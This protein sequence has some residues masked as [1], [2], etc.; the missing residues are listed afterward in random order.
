MLAAMRLFGAALVLGVATWG[1]ARL[2]DAAL[3]WYYHLAW[4]SYIVGAD[5]LNQRF[6]G[7]SLIRH[8]PRRFAWLALGSVGWWTLF[9]AINLR[10]GNWYYVMDPPSLPVRWTAGVVAFATVLPG[11]VVTAELAAHLVGTR[12]VRVAPLRWSVGKERAVLAVG[13]ACFLLPLLWPDLFFPLTWGSFVFLI[14]P[15]NRRHARESFLRDLERGEAGPFLRVLGAG[16]ICGL[17]WE[18]WNHWAR[19]KWIYTVPGFERLKLF[20]MPLLGF[21]GFPPFAVESVVATRC[22]ETLW[23]RLPPARRP[24]AA[25]AAFVAVAVLVAVVFPA[26]DAVTVES[27][28]VPVARLSVLDP[29]K[30]ARLAAAG[31]D[32]PEKLLRA[33]ETPE[34]RGTW[35]ARTS[36]PVPALMDVRARVELVMHRGLGDQR[37]R[38]LEVLGIRTVEDL[39][40]WP[41]GALAA[42]LRPQAV[43]PRDHFLERRVAAWISD[44]RLVARGEPGE[45]GE[46]AGLREVEHDECPVQHPEASRYLARQRARREVHLPAEVADRGAE[47]EGLHEH[48][49][50]GGQRQR[51][52]RPARPPGQR[53]TGGGQ[54]EL[55]HGPRPEHPAVHLGGEVP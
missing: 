21:L 52:D 39:R 31:L 8:D 7:R 23:S 16:L 48:E 32:T 5:A 44:G 54:R 9:E 18:T 12:P 51:P 17:L 36:L 10:L 2:W 19:M 43:S 24:Q 38:Q 27:F 26:A 33:L 25:T 28:Y 13:G 37:A 22:V 20:E 50:Q 41:P 14:E 47:P 45:R 34:G 11:I 42:A 53:R 3:T 29:A 46:Q 30:R 1:L 6:S 40:R 55:G 4:W 15:W 35:S 49:A